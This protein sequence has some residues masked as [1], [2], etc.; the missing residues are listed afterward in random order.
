MTATVGAKENFLN[1][2]TL[3]DQEGATTTTLSNYNS[4]QSA[5]TPTGILAADMGALTLT[6]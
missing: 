5:V 6:Q 2:A 4:S 3:K 1:Y